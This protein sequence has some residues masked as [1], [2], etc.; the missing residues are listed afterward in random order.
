MK[1]GID[2][3]PLECRLDDKQKLIKA[4]FGLTGRAIIVDLYSKIYAEEGYYCVWDSE[5]AILFASEEGVGGKVVSEV[6]NAAIKRG[7][8]DRDKYEKYGI[9]TSR[10]IQKR[11]FEAVARRVN[12]EAK[13]EYLCFNVAEKY[14][15]VN[16]LSENVCR[17]EENVYRFEQSKV[18][19]SRVDKSRVE[20][21]ERAGARV[22]TSSP[23]REE[24]SKYIRG[25]GYHFTADRFLDY[26]KRHKMPSDWQATCD[27]W[28]ANDIRDNN[29]SASFYGGSFDTEDFF[30]AAVA[31]SRKEG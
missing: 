6:V 14:K 9:L 17:N 7:I 5:V 30:E 8:F 10:G 24:V 4:E 20:K 31:R 11:Y 15:N 26:Y 19:E 2:Y 21:T 13:K 3:F 1:N 27:S 25:K 29:G 22:I 18:K 12:V 23:S 28:E 16:I